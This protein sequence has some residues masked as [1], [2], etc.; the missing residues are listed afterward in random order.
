MNTS[1]ASGGPLA[2]ELIADLA[3]ARP[4]G[5]D[6]SRVLFMPQGRSPEELAETARWLA[7]ECRRRGM[8]L[9]HRHHIEWF[10]HTRGT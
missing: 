7:A 9:A 5:V 3:A 1:P 10:G 4:A 8:H 2:P 6:R